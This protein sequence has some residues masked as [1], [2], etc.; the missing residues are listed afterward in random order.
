MRQLKKWLAGL[1]S[2][3]LI[4]P[5]AGGTAE[6]AGPTNTKKDEIVYAAM[7]V[8]GQVRSVHVVNRFR[9]EQAGLLRDYGHYQSRVNLTDER[10]L[11]AKG[12]LLELQLGPGSFYYQGNEPDTALPW[13][14][15]I[16][17]EQA[18]QTLRPKDL[19]GRRGPLTIRGHLEANP[20]CQKHYK[21][22]YLAQLSLTFD[23]R[24]VEI[25]QADGAQR[26][27]Q[28][29]K[30]SLTYAVLP[31][32][33]LDFRI[34]L[35]AQDFE[36]D[37]ISLAGIPFNMKVDLPDTTAMID[38]LS[39]LE[40]GIS[41]LN[42]GS[43]ALA[44]NGALLSKGTRSLYDGLSKLSKGADQA[45]SGQEALVNGQG[46]LQQGLSRYGSAI[47]QVV[48]QIGALGQGMEKL[49]SAIGQL[50]QG[51]DQL[52]AGMDQYGA[53]LSAYTGGVSK[54][55]SGQAD[56]SRGLAQLADQS[57]ALRQGGSDLLQAASQMKEGLSKLPKD[58]DLEGIKDLDWTKLRSDYQVLMTGYNKIKSQMDQVDPKPLLDG[59]TALADQMDK[60]SEGLDQVGQGL[61]T[62][63]SGMDPDTLPA[64]LKLQDPT[65]PDVQKLLGAIASYREGVGAAEKG[66]KRNR[67]G[68]AFLQ[69]TLEAQLTEAKKQQEKWQQD[70]AEL[71][72]NMA[73]MEASLTGFQRLLEREDLG[74]LMTSL[75]LLPTWASGFHEFD[76][77][78]RAYVMGNDRLLDALSGQVRSGSEAITD[79]LAQLAGRGPDLVSGLG[80]LKDGQDQLLSGIQAFAK[81]GASVD[82]SKIGQLGELKSGIDSI[83]ANH[84][85]LLGGQQDLLAGLRQ[86]SGGLGAAIQG[87][88]S[89]QDGVDR[90]QAGV[91][92]LAEGTQKM[93][94]ESAGM[95]DQ[96]QEKL[97]RA[98]AKFS[99]PDYRPESFAS[100]QNQAIDLVQFVYL[101]EAIRKEAPPVKEEVEV[102][103]SLWDKFLDLFR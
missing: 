87:L 93:A 60:L 9:L 98:L 83:I 85:R 34:D 19:P 20:A 71:E 97:D 86:F 23:G 18:G 96:A 89:Y 68:L 11:E 13:I 63:Q 56:F 27:Y 12:D 30:V 88:S 74:Q 66:L 15:S 6:A 53:G 44:Q 37:P 17:Y 4:L 43:Q 39:R 65:N 76:Q 33:D 5:M 82:T 92:Q 72:Q 3:A 1:L 80:R 77:G 42:K 101:S 54:L 94:G 67:N 90:Y 64:Q 52:R 69:A 75:A 100:D 50:S 40:T 79:G 95:S 45:L 99:R 35:E 2:L 73:A 21:D 91:D 102:H 28:G 62:L 78:L 84:R 49:Q 103:K 61:K 81:A 26:A 7:D 22:F 58:A 47:G 57:Q 70:F 29:S 32:D 8:K 16:D 46:Q 38:G 41:D 55:A 24:K 59:L 14:L 31:G 51:G 48:D 36:M 10:P 25:T